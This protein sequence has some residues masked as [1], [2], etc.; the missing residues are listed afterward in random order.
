MPRRARIA[1][2]AVPIF[3]LAAPAGARG[4]RQLTAVRV[5]PGA[6]QVDGSLGDPGWAGVAFSAGFLQKRPVDGAA[7]S[8]PTEVAV[9]F[10]D[11]AVI[12]GVRLTQG[13]ETIRA[14][15]TRRDT[16]KDL[17]AF[18]VSLDTY[19]D[20]RTAYTFGVT[21]GGTRFDHY[22]AS[23]DETDIDPSFD[24]VWEAATARGPT[25]WTAELR[26]PFSQLVALPQVPQR[27]GINVTRWIAA[28]G[29]QVY[30]QLIPSDATGWSSGFGSLVG[31]DGVELHRRLE[32]LPFVATDATLGAR[33]AVGV[34]LGADLKAPVGRSATLQ[35]TVLPD[36]GQVEADPAV[37]NLTTIE[38]IFDEKRP[39]FVDSRR[40]FEG[41]S[42]DADTRYFYTRRIGAIPR[43]T[44]GDAPG[45]AP[46]TAAI[47]GAGKLFGRTLSGLS[48]GAL[49]AVSDRTEATR[50]AADHTPLAPLTAFGIARAQQQLDR[51][52]STIGVIA[53]SALRRFAPGDPLAKRLPRD[54]FAGGADWNL[55]LGD[56]G[57]VLS[58]DVAAS[59]VAGSR[60]AITRVQQAPAHYLQRPDR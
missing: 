21:A 10:D 47:L 37:L 2:I 15:L 1:H 60:D 46:T 40:M 50:G 44:A 33:R 41:G 19:G 12:V 36:F 22:H 18:A 11:T 27:W 53:T 8:Q 7:P 32:L 14:G 23:D 51:R 35:A 20:H 42:I 5:G 30:W 57:G 16:F 56:G 6:I 38:T 13:P 52:G 55:R 4:T 28:T 24:P 49:V 45:G 3:V 17:D 39:F 59:R 9:A 54:A 43:Q 26:I 48:A 25:G 58:G 34:R 31:I 29:E